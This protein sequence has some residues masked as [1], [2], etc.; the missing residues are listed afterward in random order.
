MLHAFN[1]PT[2]WT[3]LIEELICTPTFS[4]MFQRAS[5][6]FFHSDNGIR[7][8]DPLSPYLFSIIMEYFTI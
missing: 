8:G 3:M 6:D 7:Q 1:F 4:F 2:K 5:I